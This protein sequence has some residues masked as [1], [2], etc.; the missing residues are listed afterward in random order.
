MSSLLN[1]S[2]D[3]GIRIFMRMRGAGLSA[4]TRPRSTSESRIWL[5]VKTKADNIVLVHPAM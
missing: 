1:T 4:W 5:K 2:S 3:V